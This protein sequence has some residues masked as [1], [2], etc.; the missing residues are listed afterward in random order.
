VKEHNIWYK[1]VFDDDLTVLVL[2][3]AFELSKEHVTTT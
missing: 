1:I 3:K 2:A